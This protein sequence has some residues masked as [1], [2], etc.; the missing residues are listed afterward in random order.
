VGGVAGRLP[1]FGD[2]CARAEE[3]E[4][5]GLTLTISVTQKGYIS[6]TRYTNTEIIFLISVAVVL[7]AEIVKVLPG[8]CF[9]VK[10]R[11]SVVGTRLP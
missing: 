3:S 2:V 1:L 10:I 5:C 9:A 7:R 4:D 8:C 11:L 6:F